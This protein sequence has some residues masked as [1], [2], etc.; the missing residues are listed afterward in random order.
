MEALLLT[1]L[2]ELL[3]TALGIATCVAAGAIV[4][5]VGKAMQ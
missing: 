3:W 1:I 2:T 4:I 5:I